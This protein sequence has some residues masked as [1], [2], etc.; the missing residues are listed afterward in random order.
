MLF[1]AEIPQIRSS[2]GPYHLV[3]D[4]GAGGSGAVYKAVD[5]RNGSTVAIKVAHDAS[6][7]QREILRKEVA[8]LWRLGREGGHPGVVRL[9]EHGEDHGRLWYAMDLVP[10]VDL[11]TVRLGKSPHGG[12]QQ[13]VP[14]RTALALG[15]RIARALAFV[16]ERGLVHADVTPRNVIVRPDGGP[17]LV[18][19][20][21][22]LYSFVDGVAREAAQFE[23]RRHGTPGYMAPEQIRGQPLDARC[24]LY[25]LGCI[26]FELLAGRTPFEGDRNAQLRQHLEREVPPLSSINPDVSSAVEHVVTSL[27][28]KDPLRRIGFAEDVAAT[29]ERLLGEPVDEGS[30][31]PS[32]RAGLR[33]YRSRLFG[34]TDARARLAE[35]LDAAA[36]GRGSFV[37]IR[38]ESGLGKTRLL[39]ELGS[40]ASSRRGFS[41]S[42]G[43][44][45]DSSG[46]GSVAINAPLQLFLPT[47]RKL[48]DD[49]TVISA[50]A[51]ATV[52]EALS[53][54][55]EFEPTLKQA[56][57]AGDSD[58]ASLPGPLARE[59][60]LQALATCLATLATEKPLVLLLD[61]LQW[62]D[63]LSRVVLT[64]RVIEDLK[65]R[66]IFIV[67]T[68]RDEEVDSTFL[69]SLQKTADE[70][71]L[72]ER[73]S[74]D[75]IAAL[76]HDMTASPL[77]PEGMIDDVFRA[78]EGNPFLAA[79]HLRSQLDSGVFRRDADGS[80]RAPLSRPFQAA[81]RSA[82][83]GPGSSSFYANARLSRVSDGARETARLA[84]VLG[85]EFKAE[86]L[87]HF[88]ALTDD[89]GVRA[90]LDE[91]SANRL[92]EEREP[93]QYRFVH[94]QLREG[95]EQTVAIDERRAL[96]RVAAE[97]LENAEGPN[98]A[99]RAARLGRHWAEAGEPA[100]AVEHL[101]R[102]ARA[103]AIV[104]ATKDA[105][106]LY[107][108]ALAL[109][110]DGPDLSL[111]QA[112]RRGAVAEALG[113]LLAVSAKHGD[114]RARYAEAALC[115]RDGPPVVRARIL[116]KRARSFWTIHKY[117][118]AR[119]CLTEAQELLD[120][121]SP[122]EADGRADEA[123]NEA[124]DEAIEIAQNAFWVDYFGR[125]FGAHTETTLD[126]MRRETAR[127]GTI[128]QRGIY[129]KCAGMYALVRSR[130]RT[131]PLIL[132]HARRC[133]A[134][135]ESDPSSAVD[136]L[137]A[138][139]SLAFVLINSRP[140]DLAEAV[141]LFEACARAAE[142]LG[143]A[144]NRARALA[145]ATIALRRLGN[146]AAVDE[147]ATRT[148]HAADEAQL[149]PYLAVASSCQAWSAW[150]R[151][152][153]PGDSGA[154]T[155]RVLVDEAREWWRRAGHPFPFR[156]VAELVAVALSAD[157]ADP[158]A[159]LTSLAVLQE[160]DQLHLPDDLDA[161]V[162]RARV[163]C[164][165]D[166][167]ESAQRALGEVLVAAR[168]ERFL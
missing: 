37:L 23:G 58:I 30:F 165:S 72:L 62:A 48:A 109:L 59:K 76:A 123:A 151:S 125:R 94:E 70:E 144:T 135:F 146:V 34:R 42:V 61:D 13:P 87:R 53:T 29:L 31:K 114:A 69:H 156:W 167:V 19:F 92:I 126:K 36:N 130:Y 67:A 149:L 147:M 3:T 129:E 163:T 52:I 86:D 20:G 134:L 14:A 57:E 132:E 4:L 60:V 78:S 74:R 39:N 128:R 155:A 93:G 162:T 65:K 133:W 127:I 22:S 83:G 40:L 8:I 107:A 38:G 157:A 68:Y 28:T 118:D 6:G 17:V 159:A 43:H 88:G 73:L 82:F 71:L 106:D 5:S 16:H 117:D 64:S 99:V 56:S 15:A 75:D 10:G 24:D 2:I 41:I 98:S 154:Q 124:A 18:D 46:D 85:R 100:R 44:S 120:A 90:A 148:R 161:A 50:S 9:I 35:R 145:Y 142:R 51:N 63:E 158:I 108:R 119:T 131:S 79:E 11:A 116:R 80:W 27:L 96:H 12:A 153:R 101:Q 160:P 26:L 66:P 45:V 54:L 113:D 115:F 33:L 137:E 143:D 164:Q 102:A 140:D 112:L 103:F 84:A 122:A 91:L 138:K 105:A 121:L 95:C 141:S 77:L 89:N 139:F 81:G 111:S 166:H 21:T 104:H 25:A 97:A 32:S 55:G 49:L 136:A 1:N 47:L 7:L 152:Q 168:R 110:P 150:K